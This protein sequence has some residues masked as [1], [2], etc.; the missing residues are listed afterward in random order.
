M[1]PLLAM[2]L[3]ALAFGCQVL[4]ST[5]V[6]ALDPYVADLKTV[7]VTAATQSMPFLFDTGGGLTILTPQ[8][9]AAIGCVP[10]GRVTG[11][12][13]NGERV[14]FARC[15]PVTLTIGG[16]DL[17]VEASILDLS[18]LLGDAPPIG[19]IFSLQT[20]QGRAFTLDW[21]DRTLVLETEQ[22]LARRVADMRA[23]SV[24]TSRQAGGAAIDLYLE[25]EAGGHS[26]WLEVDSANA[27]PMLLSPHAADQLG[28]RDAGASAIPVTLNVK[29][30]DALA[31]QAIVRP[32]IVDGIL[33]S[34]LLG[35]IMLTVD[36]RSERA[37]MRRK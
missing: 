20:L 13:G 15:G 23:V 12:R 19:G 34:S 36:L 11:F 26:I 9:A 28:L 33:S 17:R 10:F 3:G 1:K 16:V 5:T 24:R 18:K 7:R 8:T 32:L 21:S 27:G 30:F 35:A 25:I 4:P 14:D 37:W 22:S 6:I 29:G 31:A 2:S